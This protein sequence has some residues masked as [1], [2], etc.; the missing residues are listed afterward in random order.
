MCDFKNK[1]ENLWIQKINDLYLLKNLIKKTFRQ[2]VKRTYLPPMIGNLD[3]L[4][5]KT[6]FRLRRQ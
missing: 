1:K 4:S 2:N 6:D 3:T 5:Q